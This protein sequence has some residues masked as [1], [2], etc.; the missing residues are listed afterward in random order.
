[1]TTKTDLDLTPTDDLLDALMRRFTHG[2]LFAAI[3]PDKSQPSWGDYMVTH[4]NPFA[5]A[6]LAQV[7]AKRACEPIFNRRIEPVEQPP[8][9]PIERP[10][11][12]E[13]R[14]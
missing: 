14:T 7:C 12:E 11:E 4:G 3:M 5:V 2:M 10:P 9:A 1:M 8:R 6:M 13:E